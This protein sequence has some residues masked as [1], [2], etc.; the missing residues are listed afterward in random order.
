VLL[1]RQR[2]PQVR[3]CP[4]TSMLP[5]LLPPL[6][7]RCPP[8]RPPARPPTHPRG[9]TSSRVWQVLE[10]EGGITD[11]WLLAADVDKSPIKSDRHRRDPFLGMAPPKELSASESAVALPLIPQ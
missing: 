2:R 3:N 6:E 1:L 4:T 10:Q 5:H 7:L 11:S 8:P 9:K